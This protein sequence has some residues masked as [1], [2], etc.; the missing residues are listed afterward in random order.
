MFVRFKM[1]DTALTNKYT[2][3]ILRASFTYLYSCVPTFWS[4]DV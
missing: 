3:C 4:C 2:P 1:N